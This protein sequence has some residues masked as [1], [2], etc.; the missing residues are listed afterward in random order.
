MCTLCVGWKHVACHS[1]KDNNQSNLKMR[2]ALEERCATGLCS[3]TVSL[4]QA[5]A[6]TLVMDDT[7]REP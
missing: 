6:D 4:L 2:G 7:S 5:R 3:T 1:I